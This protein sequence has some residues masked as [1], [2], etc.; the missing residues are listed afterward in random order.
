MSKDGPFA[1]DTELN[2]LV[3]WFVQTKH[4]KEIKAAAGLVVFSEFHL[5]QMERL[6]DIVK[7]SSAVSVF[8]VRATPQVSLLF[9]CSNKYSGAG[10]TINKLYDLQKKLK[11]KK[12]MQPFGEIVLMRMLANR[13]KTVRTTLNTQV[14]QAQSIIQ[15][16]EFELERTLARKNQNRDTKDSIADSRASIRDSKKE[17]RIFSKILAIPLDSLKNF[18]RVLKEMRN[19]NMMWLLNTV[20]INKFITNPKYK[21]TPNM[22]RKAWAYANN[23]P[24]EGLK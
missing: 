8:L 20:G 12:P 23:N 21:W 13:M 10:G 15:E 6:Y 9:P 2:R 16:E 18:Q 4:L 5:R 1:R 14:E 19:D 24:V 7:D 11:S 17:I 22:F 3:G